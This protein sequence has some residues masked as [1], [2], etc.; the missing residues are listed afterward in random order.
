[1]DGLFTNFHPQ[2]PSVVVALSDFVW[3]L[4]DMQRILESKLGIDLRT[5]ILR[6]S[7]LHRLEVEEIEWVGQLFEEL[8]DA[9]RIDKLLTSEGCLNLHILNGADVRR[10]QILKLNLSLM[11]ALQLLLE[12]ETNT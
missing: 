8:T 12:T 2:C 9:C 3:S 5:I 11:I 7:I 4:L 1:M 6:H 10:A